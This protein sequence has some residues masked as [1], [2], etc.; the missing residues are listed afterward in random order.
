MRNCGQ[1]Q[2]SLF[3][4]FKGDGMI[5]KTIAWVVVFGFITTV[6]AGC[7]SIIGQSGPETVIYQVYSRT[8]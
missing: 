3:L 6:F 4:Q 7:A 5:R 1:K 8:S 2:V